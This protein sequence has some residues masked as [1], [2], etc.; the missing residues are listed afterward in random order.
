MAK[1]HTNAVRFRTHGTEKR[2][3]SLFSKGGDII[4]FE[5]SQRLDIR[6]VSFCCITATILLRRLTISACPPACVNGRRFR[7]P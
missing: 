2:A 7:G 4:R 3:G 1:S 5:L 6:F